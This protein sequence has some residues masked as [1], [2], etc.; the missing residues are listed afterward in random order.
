MGNDSI[1]RFGPFLEICVE[2]QVQ[3]LPARVV[4][5]WGTFGPFFLKICVTLDFGG[6]LRSDENLV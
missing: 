3:P 1:W 6:S 2:K 4:T 5:E